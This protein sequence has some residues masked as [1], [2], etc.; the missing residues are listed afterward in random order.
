MINSNLEPRLSTTREEKRERE[1]GFEVGSAPGWKLLSQYPWLTRDV[2]GGHVGVLNNSERV[3]WEF[4]D[5]IIENVSEPSNHV[6]EKQEYELI[7]EIWLANQSTRNTIESFR[8]WD[9]NDYEYEILSMNN[10]ER[11]LTSV[12]LAGKT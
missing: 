1:P 8:F 12:I 7:I 11:A 5:I 9:E 10:S 4:G 2:I 3:F 6:N